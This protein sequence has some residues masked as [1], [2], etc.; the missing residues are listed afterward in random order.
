MRAR[1]KEGTRQRIIEAAL[2]VFAD[3]G[4]NDALVDDIART[5][6]TSKGA[7]YF[8][9]P[10]KHAIFESLLHT[11]VERLVNDAEGAI[12]RSEGALDKVESA[13]QT[14]L[15]T[16]SK[17]EKATRLLFVEA[18][19]LGRAFDRQVRAAHQAFAKVIARHLQAAVDDGSICPLDVELTAYAWLG[20]IHEVLYMT[21]IDDSK[22]R[23]E[24]LATPLCQLLVRSLKRPVDNAC[25]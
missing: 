24:T 11:L 7:F 10:S 12:D 21:L 15:A 5:S 9:F 17:H 22:K 18:S 23:L 19:G 3:K 14:V 8:H 6:D 25:D 20:A 2:E 4:Y 13:L 1:D 16:L